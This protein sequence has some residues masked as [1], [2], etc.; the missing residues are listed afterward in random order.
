MRIKL[1]L[2]SVEI[3]RSYDVNT[4]ISSVLADQ[5]FLLERIQ[6]FTHIADSFPAVNEPVLL[7]YSSI[8]LAPLSAFVKDK[9]LCGVSH[10]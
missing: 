1:F 8:S 5:K 4:G 10:P 6:M 9:P 2:L 3:G 7:P